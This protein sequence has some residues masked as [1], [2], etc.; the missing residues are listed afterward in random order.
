[1]GSA[2]YNTNTPYYVLGLMHAAP[3][4]K[5]LVEVSHAERKPV[6]PFPLI[7]FVI[8][9]AAALS[10]ICFF[11][12]QGFSSVSHEEAATDAEIAAA[13]PCAKEGMKAYLASSDRAIVTSVLIEA[14]EARCAKMREIA[15]TRDRQQKTLAEQR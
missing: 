10:F 14:S 4:E 8:M 11:A 12:Y 6:D 2:R 7:C 15:I 1:M 13:S 5:R 9:L 3:M